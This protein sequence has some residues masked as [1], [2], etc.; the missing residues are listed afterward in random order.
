MDLFQRLKRACLGTRPPAA[1]VLDIPPTEPVRMRYRFSGL[2]QG[3]G[4]RYE[5][6]MTAEQLRL[7]GWARNE[8]D[9]T[10]TVEIQGP[11]GYIDEFLRVMRAVPRFSITDIQA[12]EL[13][14]SGDETTFHARYG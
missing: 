8:N 4:F 5:A 14:L 1:R 9:G 12:E 13:P 2:V 3:V 10:V 6:M 7:T 11:S